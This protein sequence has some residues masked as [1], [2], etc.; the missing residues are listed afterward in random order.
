MMKPIVRFDNDNE[1]FERD[2]YD[3]VCPAARFRKVRC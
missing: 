2:Y 1:R 3:R